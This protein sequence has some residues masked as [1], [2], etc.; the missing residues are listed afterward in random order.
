MQQLPA[1]TT[2][3]RSPQA[4]TLRDWA[5]IGFRH[6][7]LMAF[8]FMFVFGAVILIT[9]FMPRQ[10][11]AELKILVKGERADPLVSPEKDSVASRPDVTEQDVNSEVELLKSRDLLEKVALTN[12]V[13][14]NDPVRLS[15]AVQRLEKNII[16][17]PLKRTKLIRVTYK[18][19]SPHGA[20]V[21]L[22]TLSRL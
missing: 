16:V 5:A 17:E 11:E 3:I 9:L 1:T 6:A 10:Y 21:V 18:A 19:E 12:G 7:R 20:E 13:P 14:P 15:N 4:A 8:C 22:Q 2:S